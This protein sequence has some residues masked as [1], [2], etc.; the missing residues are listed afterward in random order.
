MQSSN[1]AQTLSPILKDS[2]AGKKK[3]KKK[4]SFDKLKQY[5]KVKV[6]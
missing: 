5:L 3:K 1:D 4:K 2:Y 6:K